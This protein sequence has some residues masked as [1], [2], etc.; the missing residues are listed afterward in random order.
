MTTSS[1]EEGYDD[2]A[3]DMGRPLR[4]RLRLSTAVLDVEDEDDELIL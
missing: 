4:L 3:V 1:G 2:E